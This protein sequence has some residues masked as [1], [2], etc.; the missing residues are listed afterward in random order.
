MGA[1]LLVTEVATAAAA[2][3]S[4]GIKRPASVPLAVKGRN[5][6]VCFT[7]IFVFYCDICV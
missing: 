3:R 5:G 4:K 6:E 1:G 7:V 2:S